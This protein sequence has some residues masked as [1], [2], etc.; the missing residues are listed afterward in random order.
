LRARTF[1]TN[2]ASIKVLLKQGFRS[3]GET[4]E[5]AIVFAKVL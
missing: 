4:D 5:G 1:E 2:P 3:T